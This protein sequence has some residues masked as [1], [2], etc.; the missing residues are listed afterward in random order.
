MNMKRYMLFCEIFL[1]LCTVFSV[2]VPA[3]TE[4]DSNMRNNM[5]SYDMVLIAPSHYSK[6]VQSFLDHKN[7]IGIKTILKTVESIDDEFQGYDLQEKIKNFIK[8]AYDTWDIKYALLIGNTLQNPPRYCYNNDSYHNMEPCFMSDLYFADLYD[9]QQ[10]FSSWDSDHDGLYGEWNGQSAEDHN[11]SLTPE[12][13]VGRL[14][15]HN[16]FELSVMIRKIIQYEK[17]PEDSEWFYNFIVAG[18]DTYSTA[19]GHNG[20]QYNTIEG[21]V[22]SEEA[23]QAMPG[24]EPVRLW[25][26]KGTLTSFNIVHAMNKGCGFVYFLGH[27]SHMVWLTYPPNSSRSVGYFSTLMMPLLINGGKLPICLV[28]ACQNCYFDLRFQDCWGWKFADKRF[29]GAIAT[30]GCTGLSWLGIEY[31]GG[32]NNWMNLRFFKEYANGTEILGD[33]WKNA[34]CA[35]LDEFPIDWD[36]PNGGMYSLDAKTVQE[37]VLLGDPSL[38]IG[39]YA[40]G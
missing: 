29:G 27:G 30:I 35:Y 1:L 6:V 26:S 12:I 8:T 25:A 23:I 15:C 34:I 40:N 14:P 32:G 11:I 17:R 7:S 20:S 33:V 38:K 5:D 16:R 36:T 37:W 22:Y 19:T 2:V 10:I 21:E 31:G 39:G 9:D 13:A 3:Q 18:G 24:F 28:S 4:D